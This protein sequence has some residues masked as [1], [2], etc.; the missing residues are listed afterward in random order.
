VIKRFEYKYLV[1]DSQLESLRQE[2]KPFLVLDNYAAYTGRNEYTV[3]SLYFDTDTFNSYFEKIE[4]LACRKKFRIRIYNDFTENS[5]AFLEIKSKENNCVNKN[6]ASFPFN[7]LDQVLNSSGLDDLEE[8]QIFNGGKKDAEKFMYYYK[9]VNL[10]PSVLIVYEREA[11]TG[12]F[13][14]NLRIT[15][16]KNLRSRI[17]PGIKE[18]FSD[19]DFKKA[20]EGSFI[21]EFKF[22]GNVPAWFQFVIK[23]YNLT[24]RALSKYTISIDSHIKAHMLQLY[25]YRTIT[26]SPGI[27]RSSMFK[28]KF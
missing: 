27:K 11:Y 16:D 24:R 7:Y 19:D 6:R 25:N 12:K 13:D 17:Y 10:K 22:H 23:K 18:I 3:R 28:R 8:S 26:P 21:L 14:N 5:R 9:G 15:F 20:I 1:P 2:I 4:G